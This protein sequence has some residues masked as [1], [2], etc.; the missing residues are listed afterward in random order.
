[1]PTE[2]TKCVPHTAYNKKDDNKFAANIAHTYPVVPLIALCLV[3]PTCLPVYLLVLQDN[4][5]DE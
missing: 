3:V 1:M 2:G 5:A 4:P